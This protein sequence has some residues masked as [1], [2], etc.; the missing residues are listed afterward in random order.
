MADVFATTVIAILE[1]AAGICNRKASL[2]MNRAQ[3]GRLR[4][5]SKTPGH[6]IRGSQSLSTLSCFG[7]NVLQQPA[8]SKKP[9]SIE[10]LPGSR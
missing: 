8:D 9:G 4:R 5:E 6:G 7:N 2:G 10:S 3:S 1:P